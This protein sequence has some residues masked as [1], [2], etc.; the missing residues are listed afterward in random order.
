MLK[1]L[2]TSPG[3]W[4]C[5]RCCQRPRNAFGVNWHSRSAWVS[6]LIAI[7]SH[8]APEVGH[9]LTRARALSAYLGD[10]TQLC[11]ALVGLYGHISWVARTALCA[12]RSLVER[13]LALGATPAR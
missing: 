13:Y 10:S 2:R 8:G 3:V 4:S 5:S 11:K 7:R 9:A 6:S 12:V 1:P